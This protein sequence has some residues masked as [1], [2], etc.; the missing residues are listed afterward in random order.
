MKD[1]LKVEESV[2]NYDFHVHANPIL[3]AIAE[4]SFTFFLFRYKPYGCCC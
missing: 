1:S 2:D 3:N 4:T